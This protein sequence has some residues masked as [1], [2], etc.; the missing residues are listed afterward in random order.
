M[1]ALLAASTGVA[2]ALVSP[3]AEKPKV[4]DGVR[5]YADTDLRAEPFHGMTSDFAGRPDSEMAI[6]SCRVMWQMGL[7]GPGAGHEALPDSGPAPMDHP[8]PALVACVVDGMA[9]VFPAQPEFCKAAKIPSL[10]TSG[11]RP[12]SP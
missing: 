9:A 12:A 10:L 4:V 3:K 1:T 7:L 11:G 2:F 6:E 8:V 5:C